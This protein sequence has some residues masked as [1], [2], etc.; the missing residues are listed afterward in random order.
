MREYETTVNGVRTRV[1]LS[2]E[3]AKRA[4]L[5]GGTQSG[6]VGNKARTTKPGLSDTG[7]QAVGGEGGGRARGKRSRAKDSDDT[8]DDE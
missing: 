3:D 4:G 7:S 8:G 5:S 2:D 1:Q 6:R